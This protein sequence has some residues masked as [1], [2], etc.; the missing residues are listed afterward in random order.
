MDSDDSDAP[1]GPTRGQKG[2]GRAVVSSDSESEPSNND[3]NQLPPPRAQQKDGPK[4]AFNAQSG[5]KG[6]AIISGLNDRSTAKNLDQAQNQDQDRDGSGTPTAGESAAVN[7][8]SMEVD[9]EEEEDDLD[10][11]GIDAATAAKKRKVGD[12]S[13]SPRVNLELLVCPL[14]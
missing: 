4:V 3:R 14:S 7:G 2:K 8:G 9:A 1:T 13:R 10:I 5:A 12:V 11:R 6:R